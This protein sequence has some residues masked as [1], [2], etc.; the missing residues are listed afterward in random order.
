MIAHI[1]PTIA[2][3]EPYKSKISYP[4]TD[5]YTTDTAFSVKSHGL[6]A[7]WYTFN[8]YSSVATIKTATY[9]FTS[10]I[11]IL[12]WF[13][14]KYYPAEVSS[15]YSVSPQFAVRYSGYFQ[16][17]S[18]SATFYFMGSGRMYLKIDSVA[19]ISNSQL[20][21]QY[22]AELSYRKTGMTIGNFYNIVIDYYSPHRVDNLNNTF[23]C[24]WKD[25][26]LP[27]SMPLSA[28]YVISPIDHAL[29]SN[30][31][32]ATK[33]NNIVNTE[34][35]LSKNQ[36]SKFEFT[37]P[38]VSDT[39][40][41]GY[42]YIP[43]GDY[44]VDVANPNKIIKKFRMLEYHRGYWYGATTI[45]TITKFVGQ[46]RG[47]SISKNESGESVAVIQCQDWD[48][49]LVDA[50]NMGYPN[51]TDYITFGYLKDD[52]ITGVA[53]GSKP[54]TFDGWKLTDAIECLLYNAYIDP[55]LVIQKKKRV[56]V[57]DV[58]TTT[59]YYLVHELNLENPIYL[60]LNFQYGNPLSVDKTTADSEYIWQFSIGDK[61]YDN[62]K[63]IMDNYGFLSGFNNEGHFYLK[64]INGPVKIKGIDDFTVVSGVWTEHLHPKMLSGVSKYSA[65][66]G[67]KVLAT[68]I[69]ASAKILFNRGSSYG[70][71]HVKLSNPTL[72][73]IATYDYSTKY[74]Y[75]WHVFDGLDTNV[76]YNPALLKAQ[77]G[78]SYGSYSLQISQRG[79]IPISVNGLFIYDIDD[80]PVD[81]FLTADETPLLGNIISDVSIDSTSEN[82]R[83]DV[84]VIGMLKGYQTSLANSEGNTQEIVNPNNPVGDYVVS[85]YLDTISLGSISNPQYVGRPLQMIVVEPSLVTEDR[86]NWL[87]SQILQRYNTFDKSIEPKF[88][89]IGNPLLEIDDCISAKDVHLNTVATS[90]I[91]WISE[92]AEKH[93]QNG[94]TSDIKVSAFNNWDSYIN[95]PLPSLKRLGYSVATN[96]IVSNFGVDII[97]DAPNE[98]AYISDFKYNL[99]ALNTIEIF[100]F[101][102]KSAGIPLT[103]TLLPSV[104]YIKLHR[105]I[106][107]YTKIVS[108][109]E[110][111][112]SGNSDGWLASYKLGGLTRS[113]FNTPQLTTTELGYIKANQNGYTNKQF[114]LSMSPYLSEEEGI[115]PSISF[116]LFFPGF[117]QISVRDEDNNIVDMLTGN[118]AINE[119]SNWVYLEPGTYTY[120]WGM[121]DRVGRHNEIN[122][123][124]FQYSGGIEDVPN[125]NQSLGRW[126]NWGDTRVNEA[127]ID[128]SD[129]KYIIKGNFYA[130]NTRGQVKSIY[131]I[132]IRY[133]N[134]RR[135]IS[136]T[137]QTIDVKNPIILAIR[138]GGPLVPRVSGNGNVIEQLDITNSTRDTLTRSYIVSPDTWGRTWADKDSIKFYTGLENG[139]LGYKITLKN[140][141]TNTDRLL[142]LH[143]K[144]YIF[145]SIRANVNL[146]LPGGNLS[147]GF[148]IAG[149]L[150]LVPNTTT[151]DNQG[152]TPYWCDAIEEDVVDTKSYEYKIGSKDLDIYLGPPKVCGFITP[153]LAHD[154][155]I[156]LRGSYK[157]NGVFY[158]IYGAR[159]ELANRVLGMRAK[160]IGICHFHLIDVKAT[161]FS[162]RHTRYRFNMHWISGDFTD[163]S[164][165][166]RYYMLMNYSK[167]HAFLINDYFPYWNNFG[168]PIHNSTEFG[169]NKSIVRSRNLRCV[170]VENI[171]YPPPSVIGY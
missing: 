133:K 139:G 48:S 2:N 108:S 144:R 153:N 132:R 134:R 51:I 13:S 145:T 106:L 67:N 117:I 114:M 103:E 28:G 124:V 120:S 156:L 86:A 24:L 125:A 94:F 101:R 165:Y 158:D 78:M 57:E 164:V 116:D 18:T 15:Y 6:K 118:E 104:G 100:H 127:D 61:L 52:D 163:S 26:T 129:E 93:D 147:D 137:E 1:F 79:N 109:V 63:S 151:I 19:V 25:S 136:K 64:E 9:R 157:A 83:N 5:I 8:T 56:N 111:G 102:N 49:F 98:T 115:S 107:K 40:T 43:N 90:Q 148:T 39:A 85:R 7:D 126:V 31:I 169:G 60:D 128:Y 33:L 162:G 11:P 168:W 122:S 75:A 97:A 32:P 81:T 50:L 92:I 96:Y 29:Y 99:G 149:K 55:K 30:F 88:A 89:L 105:E 140:L 10:H 4:Y 131:I 72:G 46:I 121:L 143:I 95:Y 16:A 87:S 160:N 17:Q 37:I 36:I 80:G 167:G 42:K 112:S 23:V 146:R 119:D 3:V 38:L 138:G 130:C 113:K 135:F 44:F 123:G 159:Y 34:L 73:M 27:H 66:H 62:V 77:S 76:G 70:T 142:K 84:T 69:G 12:K 47:W 154:I 35:V 14:G 22:G 71:L 58:V 155:N 141:L 45:S 161:D 20:G 166:P 110:F 152:Q 68:F 171:D 82:I 65:V 170:L 54:R 59:G 41:K 21:V 150:A 91:F 53:G 74:G